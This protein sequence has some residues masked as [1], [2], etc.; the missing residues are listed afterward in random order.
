[1]TSSLLNMGLGVCYF[2]LW[3]GTRVSL[4]YLSWLVA[5]VSSSWSIG[6]RT[7]YFVSLGHQPPCQIIQVVCLRLGRLIL[8]SRMASANARH[9]VSVVSQLVACSYPNRP[10]EFEN[11]TLAHWLAC[12]YTLRPCETEN[13]TLAQLARL[14]LYRNF[15]YTPISLG[16]FGGFSKKI[17]PIFELLDYDLY[18]R[19]MLVGK[20]WIAILTLNTVIEEI[21]RNL[22]SLLG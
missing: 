3:L 1:M 8:S 15:I 21:K 13:C 12:I 6:Q 10:C 7:I 20:S 4:T 2:N 9:A 22:G 18:W 16:K 11:C 19:E 5:Y 14:Y 17:T